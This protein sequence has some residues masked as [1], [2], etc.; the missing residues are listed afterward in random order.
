MKP[1]LKIAAWNV[2]SVRVRESHLLRWLEANRPDVLCL[3]ELK[4][5]DDAFPTEAVR[6]LGYHA[7]T[8]GQKTYNG[9]AILSRG[10][11]GSVARGFGDGVEDDQARL[12][13]A[14]IEGVRVVSAYVPNGGE[15]RSEKWSYKLVWLDRLLAWLRQHGDP[16]QP[17][18]ICGDFNIAPEARDVHAVEAWEHGVLFHPRIRESLGRLLQWGLVDTFRLHAPDAGRF[19]WWDYREGALQRD[20]GLR[21]DLVLATRSLAARCV[22]AGID[23]AEREAE[24]ASDHAPVWS[25][26]SR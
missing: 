23:R 6:A 2:N 17:L 4:C 19:S 22:E 5:T 15:M 14:T 7:E 20:A 3:Q 26:F 10:A 13:A 25:A 9:V 24:K 18:A 1:A 8:F 21:I 12:I 16:T 11:P